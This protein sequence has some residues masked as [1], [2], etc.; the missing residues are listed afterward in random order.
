MEEAGA[1]ILPVSQ[2]KP[3]ER[4]RD[5]QNSL[6]R[7]RI[8]S[9]DTKN[10]SKLKQT[11]V[12]TILNVNRMQNNRRVQNDYSLEEPQPVFAS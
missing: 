9:V 7:E 4:A 3:R 2:K 10:H 6:G 1:E 11:L 5:L 12:Q 8:Q